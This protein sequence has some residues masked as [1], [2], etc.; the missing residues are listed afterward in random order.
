MAK[1]SGKKTRKRVAGD[2]PREAMPEDNVLNP[3]RFPLESRE[4][5]PEEI[6]IPCFRCGCNYMR[7]VYTRHRRDRRI[8]RMRQCNHCGTR[9]M[10]VERRQGER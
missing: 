8:V 3:A 9:V 1:G 4:P 2:A 6:G 10:T 7:V 5:Q